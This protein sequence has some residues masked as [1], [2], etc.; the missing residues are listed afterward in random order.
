MHK[1]F[2]FAILFLIVAAA[3]F[4]A[5]R[6]WSNLQTAPRQ[7]A[8]SAIPVELVEPTR[9]N[10]RNIRDFNG[11]L[12]PWSQ[13]DV[14][15]KVGGHLLETFGLTGEAVKSGQ[16]LIQL[17]DAEFIQAAA[18]AASDLAVAQSQE[19]EAKLTK[20]LK[21]REFERQED[22]YKEE[23][24]SEAQFDSVRTALSSAKVLY[25]MRQ[26]EVASRQTALDNAKLKLTYTKIFADWNTPAPRYIAKW[27]ADAGDLVAPNQ[28]LLSII[29]IDR[30]KGELYVI[31]RDYPLLKIGQPAKISTD[32]Y[33]GQIFSGSI[34]SISKILDSNTRQAYVQLAVPNENLQLKPGMYIRAEIEFAVHENALVIPRNALIRR[35]ETQGVFVA[36]APEIID[37]R[38]TYTVHFVPVETGLVED[39]MVEIL[40]PVLDQPV[41]TLG[42][43][44]MVDNVKVYVPEAVDQASQNAE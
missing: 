40:S 25:S 7:N 16:Q 37:N 34:R 28:P 24:I 42:N 44:L 6:I 38:K 22:L 12:V 32:A 19:A 18:Q 1:K 2:W 31:E 41:V 26:A 15:P 33:P 21:Q 11:T 17:D 5:Y 14:A 9:R 3:A 4:T 27:Y 13:F 30:L 35:N 23:I 29:E 43:H 36:S 10:L 20:D 39:G 8:S